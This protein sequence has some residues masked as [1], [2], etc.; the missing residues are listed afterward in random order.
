MKEQRRKRGLKTRH[1]RDHD[2]YYL[3]VI[4]MCSKRR[5]TTHNGCSIEVPWLQERKQLDPGL[6][7]VQSLM[8]LEMA[9]VD[10]RFR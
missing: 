10:T 3:T 4:H 8:A 6:D 9:L 1:T 5:N 2:R 7:Q